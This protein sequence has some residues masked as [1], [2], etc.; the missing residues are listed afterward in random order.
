MKTQ[1]G[2]SKP[3]RYRGWDFSVRLYEHENGEF[4]AEVKLVYEWEPSPGKFEHIKTDIT[5]DSQEKAENDVVHLV[6]SHIDQF[7]GDRPKAK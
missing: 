5:F 6:K 1:V 3:D 4:S 2:D 7:L